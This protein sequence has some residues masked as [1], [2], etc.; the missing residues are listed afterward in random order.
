MIDHFNLPVADLDRSSRF[1][2]DAL[3]PLGYPFLMRDGEAIG[4]G[5]N[6]WRF[7]IVAIA[8]PIPP[9]HLAFEAKCR[10]QVD[11]FFEAALAAGGRSLGAPGIRPHY[12]ANYYAAYVTDPD[13]HN[14]EAVCRR[15]L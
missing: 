11:R 5:V 1:Y 13:G 12:D 4:F 8:S 7:G 14:I 15:P 3:A 10:E 6:A 9:L 2:R